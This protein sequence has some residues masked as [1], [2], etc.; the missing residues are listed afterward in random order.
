MAA[1]EANSGEDTPTTAAPD[2]T[3]EHGRSATRDR[4]RSRAPASRTPGRGTAH[5]GVRRGA[6]RESGGGCER[7]GAERGGTRHRGTRRCAAREG[8]NGHGCKGTERQDAGDGDAGRCTPRGA[9]RRGGN[10]G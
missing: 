9:A 1:R 6:A 10:G 8:G 7:K 4:G 2:R 5:Q 3:P